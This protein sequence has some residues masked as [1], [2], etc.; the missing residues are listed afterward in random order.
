MI[1]IYLI[2]LSWDSGISPCKKLSLSESKRLSGGALKDFCNSDVWW[3]TTQ[4]SR[5]KWLNGVSGITFQGQQ[6]KLQKTRPVSFI[7]PL[8]VQ[9]N[10][11]SV[12]PTHNSTSEK[13]CQGRSKIRAFVFP[14]AT[15][16][17]KW[18]RHQDIPLNSQRC[19]LLAWKH[20]NTSQLGWNQ[21]FESSPDLCTEDCT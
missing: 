6:I 12:V 13:C 1:F 16:T 15:V 10:A 21:G 11:H 3:L 9:G 2:V 19:S 4:C 20:Y 5:K 8:K 7:L 14:M 18:L 17:D